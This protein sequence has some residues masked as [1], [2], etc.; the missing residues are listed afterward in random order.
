MPSAPSQDVID[1]ASPYLE[2][3]GIPTD[4]AQAFWQG[5]DN[6]GL[7]VVQKSDG[8]PAEATDTAAMERIRV[9][10]EVGTYMLKIPAGSGYLW[11]IETSGKTAEPPTRSGWVYGA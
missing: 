9:T 3:A 7:T 10:G 8:T 6:A 11:C 2:A 4:L 5:L 1:A